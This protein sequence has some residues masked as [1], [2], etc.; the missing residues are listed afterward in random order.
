MLFQEDFNTQEE[1]LPEA[2]GPRLFFRILGQ[3]TA[4]LLL[5]NLLFLLSCLAVV[6]IPPALLA[7]WQVTRRML[8]GQTVHGWSQYWEA[9]RKGWKRAWGAFALTALPMATAGYG[10]W[11]YLRFAETNILCYLP[12]MF[13]AAVFLTALLASSYL[14]GLL[15]DGRPLTRETLLLSLK[16]GL[17][18]PLRPALAAVSWHG[19]LAAGI[20]WLPL[21]GVYLL[22]IGFSVPCLLSQFFIR[23][24]VARLPGT[25]AN[26]GAS[27]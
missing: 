5:L 12:F 7:L 10:A 8:T 2:S 22:L 23:T 13:C 6:T 3:E 1:E 26:G 27:S 11:F 14:W 20:L 15:A 21:S 16:L 19:A 17:G 4:A 9:F 25:G 24:V 18:K